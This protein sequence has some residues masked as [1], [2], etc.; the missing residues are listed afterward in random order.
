MA[1]RVFWRDHL[2]PTPASPP[3]P[4]QPEEVA[5]LP[6]RRYR[7][8]AAGGGRCRWRRNFPTD[9]ATLNSRL[10]NLLK[11]FAASPQSS[12]QKPVTFSVVHKETVIFLHFIR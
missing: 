5:P 9:Q 3:S 4:T 2:S 1:S 6:S 11:A 8:A 7:L 10:E 12:I